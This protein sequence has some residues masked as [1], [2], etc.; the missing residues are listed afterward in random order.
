[1]LANLAD[2]DLLRRSF[3]R[4]EVRDAARGSRDAV[5]EDGRGATANGKRRE[6]HGVSGRQSRLVGPGVRRSRSAPLATAAAIEVGRVA[7]CSSQSLLT[8][9]PNVS[10]P[11]RLRPYVDRYLEVCFA[12]RTP[13]R[14]SEVAQLLGVS[15]RTAYD[16][17]LPEIGT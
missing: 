8:G 1:M 5:A 2:E 6:L 11:W 17:P 3:R 4:I 10:V 7:F 15:E 16:L 13:P 12:H 14:V 9:D